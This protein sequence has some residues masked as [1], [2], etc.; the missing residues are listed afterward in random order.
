MKE[1]QLNKIICEKCGKE[2]FQTLVK[3]MQVK[4]PKCSHVTSFGTYR[5]DDTPDKEKN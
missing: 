5:K 1:P 3:S 4:C 2:L